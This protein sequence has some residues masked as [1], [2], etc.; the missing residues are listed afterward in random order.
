LGC[1]DSGQ[2]PGLSQSVAP[3]ARGKIA[4]R[5]AQG[6]EMKMKNLEWKNAA[7]VHLRLEAK[8]QTVM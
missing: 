3:E 1:D 2:A 7:V 8:R 6:R 5:S 4:T